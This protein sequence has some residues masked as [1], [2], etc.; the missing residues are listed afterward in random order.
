MAF[1]TMAVSV[2]LF[3][4]GLGVSGN[5]EKT[6]LDSYAINCTLLPHPAP[7]PYHLRLLAKGQFTTKGLRELFACEYEPL[8]GFEKMQ[9]QRII[10]GSSR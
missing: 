10:L 8:P 1:F 7:Y 5:W 9:R 4:I 6:V 3:G 2:A